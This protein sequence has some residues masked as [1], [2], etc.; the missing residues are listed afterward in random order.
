MKNWR[1]KNDAEGAG[2]AG[3]DERRVGVQPAQ[4][5]HDEEVG[6]QHDHGGHEHGGQDHGS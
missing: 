4:R 1:R 5:V 6:D 2:G 3:D